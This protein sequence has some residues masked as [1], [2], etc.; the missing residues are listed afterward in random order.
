MF[1]LEKNPINLYFHKYCEL[2]TH[3]G[4]NVTFQTV[5]PQHI[6][7]GEH[8]YGDGDSKKQGIL[9]YR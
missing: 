4:I 3:T 6:L 7:K 2:Q 5:M 9:R 8:G 1:V